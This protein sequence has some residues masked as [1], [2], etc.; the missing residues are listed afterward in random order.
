MA[1]SPAVSLDAVLALKFGIGA[2]VMRG[3]GCTINDMWDRDIDREVTRTRGR[4]LASGEVSM[5]QAATFLGAQLSVGLA[6]L[7]TFDTYTVLLASSSLVLVATYPLAKR[8][9][10]Y[11]QAVLGLTFN[12][13]ALVGWAAVQGDISL[14]AVPTVGSLYAGCFFWTMLYD[15]IY[16][17]QDKQDDILVG[18]KSSAL[19]IGEKDAKKWLG[20]FGALCTLCFGATGYAM[21]AHWPYY[22]GVAMSGTHMAWQIATVRLDDR[23][24]LS[25]KFKSNTWIGALMLSGILASRVIG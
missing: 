14:S 5:G 17:H 21:D 18:V 4:P 25:R 3:A 24:D 22:C 12:W 11:P 8:L 9:V 1:T 20:V 2:V 10:G 23:G 16:A 6:I 15:T 13:G 19:S 7:S